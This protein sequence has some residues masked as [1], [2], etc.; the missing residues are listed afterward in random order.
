MMSAK[1]PKAA[2]FEID[3]SKLPKEL[4]VQLVETINVYSS[5]YQLPFP[6]HMFIE[7][8]DEHV[9]LFIAKIV[10]FIELFYYILCVILNAIHF[11]IWLP[12]PQ[13][14][15][16][17]TMPSIVL[18]ATLAELTIALAFQVYDFNK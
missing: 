17:T 12:K 8:A 11:G 10:C 15:I 5:H 18:I 14:A 4:R 13:Y 7:K 16:D 2:E 3:Q 1:S 6:L 9:Y